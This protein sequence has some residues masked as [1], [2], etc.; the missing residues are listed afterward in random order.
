MEDEHPKPKFSFRWPVSR[1]ARAAQLFGMGWSLE[2]IAEDPFVSSSP[3]R[4]RSA[5]KRAKIFIEDAPLPGRYRLDLPRKHSEVWRLAAARRH[6]TTEALLRKI[7]EV[8]AEEPNYIDNII[9]DG[10]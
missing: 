8:L 6:T 9:D 1:L 7:A 10:R 4:V 3:R 5:L 2:E